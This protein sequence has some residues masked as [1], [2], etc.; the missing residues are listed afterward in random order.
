MLKENLQEVEARVA[1]ACARAGRDRDEV[2]LIAV[3]KTKPVEMIE[4]IY[5]EGIRDFG[6][7]HPQ[8]IRDKFPQLPQDVR[9]HMIGHLQTNKIKYIIERACMVHSVESVR[10]AEA[11]SSAAVSHGLVMPVL[12]EVNMAKEE[13]KYGIMPE[14]TERFIREIASL[15][16]IHVRG[17][18]TIAPYTDNAEEN[19]VYFRDMKKLSVDIAGKNIDNVDMCEL[20][21]GMTGDYEVAIEEGATMVRVGT[22]IFGARDYSK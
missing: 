6:E 15:P 7:N 5:R 8:E 17:L 19:R 10:L 4:E 9:W 12:V 16:G 2:L 1:D 21:M 14:D 13:S 11:I 18:M 22:G 20:S 3:S